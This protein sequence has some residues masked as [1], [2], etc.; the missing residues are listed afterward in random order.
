MNE[1][2]I[3]KKSE[4]IVKK[5]KECKISKTNLKNRCKLR[6]TKK[7]SSLSRVLEDGDG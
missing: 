1:I 6:G 4:I 7:V 3:K 5:I 2:K